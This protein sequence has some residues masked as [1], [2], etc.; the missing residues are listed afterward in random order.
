[1]LKL[2][3]RS[4]RPDSDGPRRRAEPPGVRGVPREASRVLALVLC[5]INKFTDALEFVEDRVGGGRPDE[6]PLVAVVMSHIGVD[7]RHQFPD[8][9]ERATANRVLGDK[10]EPALNLVEPA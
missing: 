1:M 7:L 2:P 3:G 8:V 6:G 5:P 10:R 4:L 9:A